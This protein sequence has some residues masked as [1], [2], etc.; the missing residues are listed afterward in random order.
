[1]RLRG[2]V[3]FLTGI[4]FMHRHHLSLGT[5]V[6]LFLIASSVSAED[7]W[8]FRGPTGQ[9]ISSEKKL[10]IKW[11]Q[12]DNVDWSAEIPGK[13]WSSPICVNSRIYLT[14]AVPGAGE[15]YSLR[16]MCLDETNGQPL[17]D[18]ELFQE[19]AANAGPVHSKN[20]HAS[21]SPVL[22]DDRLYVHFGHEGTACLDLEGNVLW[23]N[24]GLRYN[25]GHGNGGSPIVIDDFLVFSCDGAEDP[26]IVALDRGTGD[27]RWRTQRESDAAKKFSFG[28]PLVIDVKG[29]KQIISQGSNVVAA[30][31]PKSGEEIWRARY[32]GYSLIPRPVF[33]QG[34]IFIST[35]YDNPQVVAVR[36]DG[37]GDVTDT[38]IAW[39]LDRGAP[40]TPS[41]LLVGNEVY[42]VSD[43]GV[44]SCVDA[45]SGD[46]VWQQR[47]GGKFSAS[48][49]YAGGHIYFQSEEGQGTVIQAGRKFQ[50]LAKN[51]LGQATLASYGVGNGALLIRS[52]SH[53]YRIK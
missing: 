38:H 14:T 53:L 50:Q 4:S 2:S 23:R 45:K 1:L 49:L 30:Y 13:G 12:T 25:P 19:R 48:P 8:Q 44:A 27:V 18:V 31:N 29:R 17:W 20:S 15:N 32:D 10:P 37:S 39:R 22:V 5:L 3:I 16:T 33:G 6:C 34:M 35:G 9:G 7:W 26:Y 11:S 46:V 41:L 51:D 36:V 21:P 24:S 28:T 42:M 43:G 52:E 40:N 47:L